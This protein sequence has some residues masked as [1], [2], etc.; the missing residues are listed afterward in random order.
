M[1]RSSSKTARQHGYV[2][3][4]REY[5]RRIAVDCW[6]DVSEFLGDAAKAK[7]IAEVRARLLNTKSPWEDERKRIATAIEHMRLRARANGSVMQGPLYIYSKSK[8][9]VEEVEKYLSSLDDE[10]YVEFISKSRI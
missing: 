1:P 4:V 3:T 8:W 5:R 9:T 2:F 7:E 6:L 10:A